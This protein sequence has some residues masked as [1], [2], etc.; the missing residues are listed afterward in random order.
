LRSDPSLIWTGPINDS[1]RIGGSVGLYDTTLRDGEQSV[2]VVLDPQQKLELARAIDELGIERIEAG[3]P[4]VSQDDWDAVK[5]I[6]GAGLKAE[7]WGFSRAVAADAEALVELGVQASVI[8]S[9][10]SDAKLAALGVTRESMLERIRGAVS[11][12]A[13]HGITVAFF[14]V[15]GTRAD[16][17]FFRQAYATAVDAGA[18]EAVVVDTIGVAT[19]EAVAELVG[20][21]REQLGPD[22]PLHFHGHND[23]GLATAA[24]TAAVRAGASW[25]QGTINGMGERGGNANLIE[26]AM[27]LDALYGVS[28]NLRLDRAREVSRLVREVSGYELEPWKPVV[29]EN[30][31]RRESGAVASQFHDPPAIEP[32][33]SELVGAERAIVLGKKSGLDSIR[34]ACERLGLDVPEEQWPE[35]L[36]KVKAL[37]AEKH[38]LVNDDEFRALL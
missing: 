25:V 7:V 6:S 5:L 21:T 32:Y 4:R 14:G 12:A 37:G 1:A 3:F 8:E 28:T 11:F 19:P 31:F 20:S 24:A 22:V 38:G 15:D 26:V 16:P 33:S 34:I 27:T 18:K 30:L 2:G 23:F 10:I 35:L 29:G 17:E 9:P 36:A 13:G